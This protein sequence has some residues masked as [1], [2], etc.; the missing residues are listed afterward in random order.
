MPSRTAIYLIDKPLTLRSPNGAAIETTVKSLALDIEGEHAIGCRLEFVLPF[1]T[2]VRVLRAGL[3]ALGDEARRQSLASLRP[4][5]ETTIEAALDRALVPGLAGD[6]PDVGAASRRLL[7]L[8]RLDPGSPLVATE[9]WQALHVTQPEAT[10]PGASGTLASGFAVGTARGQEEGSLL[11]VIEQYFRDEGWEYSR[12]EGRDAFDARYDDE[13][14][15]WDCLAI[16]REEQQQAILYVFA[17]GG[18]PESRRLAVA[19]YLVRA[20][21]GLIIGSFEMDFSDGEVRYRASIDVD[22]AELTPALFDHLVEASIL[23]MRA[24]EPGLEAVIAGAQTPAEA[25]EQAEGD[26]L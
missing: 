5:E 11:K 13:G 9:S 12:I 14:T 19:E 21:Y 22:E 3:F 6:P 16:A 2:Y 24:Y 8:E 25:I 26:T 17:P 4:G 20:N 18:A 15:V 1:E 23:A 7:E 10:P